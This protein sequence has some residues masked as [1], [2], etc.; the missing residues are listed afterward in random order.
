MPSAV[1]RETELADFVGQFYAD[2]LGFVLGC[3]PWREDG[4]LVDHVGP[5]TWQRAA[6]ERI[7]EEV[8]ARKF[9]GV[10]PVEP[11]R[12][13]VSSGHGVGKSTLQAWLVD[14]VM[15]TRPGAQGSVTANTATQ[16]DTKT[17]AAIQ[18]WTKLCLTAHWFEVNS[19]RLYRVGERESWFCTPQSCKEEN[20]EA[21]AGQHAAN[22]TSLYVID[23]GSAVPD[24]IYEV[25]E[26]GL[27]DGEPM[28]FVF[29]NC[30]R[31]V[32]KFHRICFG[33]ERDRW[34]PIIVDSRESRFTNKQQIAE[35]MQDYGEDSDFFR[36]R[37]RGLPPAA[38]DL[39]YIDSARIGAAQTREAF[40]LP[41]DPL[42]AGLDVARGGGDEN[43]IWFR[44]GADA[45]TIPAIRIP[46]EQTRD[47]MRLVTV[48]A[49]VLAREYSGRKIDMLFV[50][51]TG[52]GGPIC[53][54]LKQLG[55]KNIN[56][57]C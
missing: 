24:I 50:D 54:R 15:S 33:S 48:A 7:G 43:V 19:T 29:G 16:L 27:T 36:V 6:L 23:E 14:W 35:W 4:P 55:H 17:W 13:A 1:D 25:A 18:R 28:I 22:S 39:Q 53:D 20:S 8:R 49:D 44:R 32:G 45:R 38:S 52:I 42:I 40:H 30:T 21:F 34:K 2:P 9:D 56:E 11:L 3:Y 12:I 47:S 5:D 46:G 31:S 26:G 51:G 57:V 10:Y 37:V 41:D